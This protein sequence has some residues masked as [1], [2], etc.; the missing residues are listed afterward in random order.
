MSAVRDALLCICSGV[1]VDDGLVRRIL[2]VFV[3]IAD[4]FRF[5]VL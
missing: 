2:R 5:A 3:C 1:T 4:W